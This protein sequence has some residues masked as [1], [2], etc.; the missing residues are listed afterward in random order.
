MVR[1]ELFLKVTL[2]VGLAHKHDFDFIKTR[3]SSIGHRRNRCFW[4]FH[5]AEDRKLARCGAVKSSLTTLS[6]PPANLMH[7]RWTFPNEPITYPLLKVSLK[8]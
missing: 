6:K 8:V 3:R 5:A 7:T 4:T 2:R 1:L